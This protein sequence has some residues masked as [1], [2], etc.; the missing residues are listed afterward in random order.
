MTAT[1]LKDRL[2]RIISYDRPASAPTSAKDDVTLAV[3]HAFQVL[4]TDVPREYRTHYT[5][6]VDTVPLVAGTNSY[7]LA[8]D[9]QGVMPPISFLT[10]RSPL[11]AATYLS[12][13]V[14]YGFIRGTTSTSTNNARPS[15]YY[16]ERLGQVASD[17]TR[18]NLL[19][20]PTPVVAESLLV[21]VEITAPRFVVADFCS[22]S[23][24][25]LQMPHEY[26]ESLLLPIASYLLAARSQR[27]SL[28]ANIEALQAD[29]SAALRRA[30]ATDPTATATVSDRTNDDT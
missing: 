5:K 12:E 4:W 22:D 17:G 14:Q 10:D 9:V 18:I 25:P 23:P 29:Y 20:A 24:P 8:S 15:I 6:R 7:E 3:N 26:A 16:L 11:H 28:T 13:V 19:V 1:E 27:T 30:G 2:L 21:N